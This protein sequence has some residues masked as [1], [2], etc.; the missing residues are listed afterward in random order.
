VIALQRAAL[1]DVEGAGFAM[2]RA[3]D[4]DQEPQIG[5]R[6]RALREAQKLTA[7]ELARRAGISKSLLSQVE[8]G[9][10][11]ASISVLRALARGL[12]VP[13][14]TLFIDQKSTHTLVRKN[15]RLKLDVP[16]SPI[17]RELLTPRLQRTVMM[18]KALIRPGDVSSP[19][20]P[21]S[22]RG[23]ECVYVLSGWVE[24][25]ANG[26]T[27]ALEEGDTLC[28]DPVIPHVLRNVSNENAEVLAVITSPE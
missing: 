28:F 5:A 11:N 25:E 13:F 2:S 22:H 15:E 26:T 19:E 17:E 20:A 1:V 16:G 24:V 8:L 4:G 27:L 21:T 14:F 10:S 12:G 3:I 23:E 6:I 7:T 18:V 9:S